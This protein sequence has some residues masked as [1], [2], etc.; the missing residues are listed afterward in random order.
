MKIGARLFAITTALLLAGALVSCGT[1]GSSTAPAAPVAGGVSGTGTGTAQG[2][3]GEV[4]VTITMAEGVITDVVVVGD[5]ETPTVGGLVIA[6]APDSIREF[7]ADIDATSGATVTTMAVRE[8]AGLAIE[9]IN[10]AAAAPAPAVEEVAPVEDAV[11][12]VE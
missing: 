1:T 4:S 7:G 6:S 5:G 2:Y 11:A 9:Q 3:G 12:V 8:A 10:A